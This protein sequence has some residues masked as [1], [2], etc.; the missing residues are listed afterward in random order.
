MAYEASLIEKKWQKIW[1]ENEYFEPKDDLNLPKKYILSMFP[2][3]SGRIHM[4]HVRNYTIGDA[5]ARYYRK[6]GFNVLHPIG[7]DSF[8]MPA[9]NAAIKHKIHPK[10]WT[11]EN[12]AYMKKELFSL[13]FSFSKKRMFA[14]SD[15]LYTKFEQE[16]FIKMFEKGLIYTK[17]ANVNWCEQDQTVLANEQVEDGKCWRCGHEVVQKKMPGYYVKIT[18]Y[19]EEL[20]KDLEEL[21]DKWPNQVLTMQE[22]WIGKS[23]GLEFSL[24]LD[25]ESKQKT[26]ESSL[27]VF[28]T[29]ADTIYGVSY[30][31]LAPEHKIVQNLLSQNLLNQ[32]VLNKIKV[33]QNQSPRERQ[34]S[35]KE[36]YFLGIYVIHPLSGEKIP[37]WV[38]NFVLA[39]YGSGAVMAVPAHDERDFEFATK[40]NL[41]IKQVIQTQENLP[42]MQKLGKLINSQEFDNLDCNEARL[43]IISQFE[44]KNIGKRVVNFKIRD[45]GVSRQRYWGAPIPMIKCQSCGIVPQKLEN[46]PITLPEDVQITGEGN[47]LDKHPTWKNCICPKCGKEAQKESDTLDTFFESSWYFARFASDEKTWQ[48][49]ALDEKSVKYWMSVDQYIGGIE[50]AILH[51]LYA[52][53]FQK[54]LRDLG[55]LTQN[56]PFDRLLTQ[57]MV[58]KDGAKMSKS[59]GN[60]VD[61]DEIIEKYGADTARLFILFAAPPAKELEWNDDAVEGAYRFI[62]KLYDRAQ[63]VKKGELVELKQEN[64][65][66]E[67]KYARLKVYEA[68]KKSFEVYHQSFAFNTLIAACMEALN[69]LA[70][71]KNE[72]L[73][74]EAF[75]IIL[76]ILE[77]IIPH[78][79]FELSEELFKC[80]NFK[81]LELKEEV[82]VKDTLNLAVSI[83]GKK[84]AEFEISSSA[85]KEEILAFAKENTAKW[86]EGKS[87]VKEIYV[88]GKLVNLVIK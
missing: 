44:A 25:E 42:Y 50:H 26:K 81:K 31:A 80:K 34:S 65:N 12:I 74:Q 53:F 83:N 45:W 41:A 88:E 37:L 79:C 17:E 40:Y 36:G 62:C 29:R 68:L 60:V 19:A 23:E 72:A 10:S 14:T 43:K 71:C 49:K 18:A 66:K 86:L 9:E 13:G 27:E 4:G 28:T 2:Y 48:E 57:G 21:K 22:N 56:E 30:I 52:R 47:P 73:E 33:I 64:L 39:D 63:N 24:N 78:V 76:N 70:L 67:E 11:Y 75:Y 59:K 77:P 51:L 82:F 85:S 54:A 16:F 6:I 7:F 38:A 20:L 5:L 46:L 15:P 35:E 3:P 58:L 87:I 32:D 69:A 61:P 1:D 84:R 55:Y 8:G